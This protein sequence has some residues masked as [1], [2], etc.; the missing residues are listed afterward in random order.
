MIAQHEYSLLLNECKKLPPAKGMY[1]IDDYVENLLLTV[2]HSLTNDLRV[3]GISYAILRSFYV[4]E[5][6]LPAIP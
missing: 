6:D 5:C 4:R 1:L 2:L 3:A